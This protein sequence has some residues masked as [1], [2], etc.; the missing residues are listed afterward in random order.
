MNDDKPKKKWVQKPN[1][2]IV[3]SEK[4]DMNSDRM[5]SPRGN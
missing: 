2:I 5:R 1:N 4:K 3:D